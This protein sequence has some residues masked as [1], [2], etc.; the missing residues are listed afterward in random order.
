MSAGRGFPR[1][2]PAS[3]TLEELQ[4]FRSPRPTPFPELLD[5]PYRAHLE[6]LRSDPH[7]RREVLVLK[8]SAVGRT[9]TTAPGPFRLVSSPT[10]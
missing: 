4:A 10:A 9:E 7:Y 8:G 5:E 3:Q 1:L 6:A 2:V